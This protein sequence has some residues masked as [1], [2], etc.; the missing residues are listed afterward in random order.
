MFVFQ[1]TYEKKKH[2]SRHT[3]T[4]NTYLWNAFNITIDAIIIN[5]SL[6]VTFNIDWRAALKLQEW[7]WNI[8]TIK[9]K[10]SFIQNT[11]FLKSFCTA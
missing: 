11:Y 5:S 7:V 3:I 1:T 4:A 9:I 8:Y 2:V 10:Y 6:N